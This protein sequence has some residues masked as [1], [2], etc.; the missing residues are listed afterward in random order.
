MATKV[1]LKK[2][3][4]VDGRS[5]FVP[6]LKLARKPGRVRH[7]HWTV[8]GTTGTCYVELRENQKRIQCPAGS[9]VCS[10]ELPVRAKPD[11]TDNKLPG[12]EHLAK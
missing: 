8:R 11:I 5:Q 1:N 12:V 6:E 3:I 10:P 7:R 9:D 4:S 2:Y